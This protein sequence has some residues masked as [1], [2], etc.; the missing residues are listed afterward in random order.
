MEA[1]NVGDAGSYL[2]SISSLPSIAVAKDVLGSSIGLFF[3]RKEQPDDK[4]DNL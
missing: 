1:E 2:I 3:S 4:I